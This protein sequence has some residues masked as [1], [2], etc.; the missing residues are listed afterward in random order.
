MILLTLITTI[1]MH[2]LARWGHVHRRIHMN[3]WTIQN[4]YTHK[5]NR[6]DEEMQ[7]TAC[8]LR[9]AVFSFSLSWMKGESM[10]AA[11][12]RAREQHTLVGDVDSVEYRTKAS[13]WLSRMYIYLSIMCKYECMCKWVCA[14]ADETG[15]IIIQKTKEKKNKRIRGRRWRCRW[16][17]L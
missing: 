6:S 2:R 4:I 8:I 3:A 1:I 9:V 17:Q 7:R 5:W 14:V 15:R 12:S 11:I 10:A 13:T 16:Q